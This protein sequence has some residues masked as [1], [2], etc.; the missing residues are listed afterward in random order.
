MRCSQLG[1]TPGHLPRASRSTK[2]PLRARLTA[3]P[4]LL[5]CLRAFGRF[6]QVALSCPGCP[7]C[8]WCPCRLHLRVCEAPEPLPRVL[9]YRSLSQLGGALPVRRAREPMP[10]PPR[11]P[12]ASVSPLPPGGTAPGCQTCTSGPAPPSSPPIRRTGWR[13]LAVLGRRARSGHHCTKHKRF[14][15]Y[16][17]SIKNGTPVDP[18]HAT[19]PKRAAQPMLTW[20]AAVSCR[21]EC[22]A[23]PV[24]G[25]KRR[26]SGSLHPE[27]P[28]LG[29]VLGTRRHRR[30]PCTAAS[31]SNAR[32]GDWNR[33]CKAPTAGTGVVRLSTH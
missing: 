13:G 5:P 8:P 27:V 2:G 29:K 20:I 4:L 32:T 22:I 21:L 33:R 24:S 10:A 14:A 11:P 1:S 31:N 18:L 6:G 3:P 28:A 23:S 9:P 17:N 15:R 19:R 25:T 16:T 30:E 7:G 26:V 12:P